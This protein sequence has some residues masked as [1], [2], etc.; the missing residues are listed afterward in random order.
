MAGILTGEGVGP[1][2]ISAALQVLQAIEQASGIA[3]QLRYGGPIGLAALRDSGTCLSPEVIDFC[4]NVFADGGCIFCGP[5]GGDF[6]YRLRERFDLY[7]KFTPIHELAAL[8]GVSRIKPAYLAG[9]DMIVVRENSAGLYLGDSG[10]ENLPCG[11]RLATHQ[12]RYKSSQVERILDVARRLAQ[13]RRGS[14]TVVTKPGGIP[15]ISSLWLDALESMETEG[16]TVRRLEI[17]YAI[18]QLLSAPHE[19]DVIVAPN[20]FGDVLSD[21]AALLMGARGVSY[22]G[23]FG[24]AGRAVYQTGHG[25]AKDLAG[26]NQA[27]PLGQIQSLAMMLRESFGLQEQAQWIH[28]AIDRVLRAGWRTLDIAEPDSRVV[29]TREMGEIVADAVQAEADAGQLMYGS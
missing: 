8:H 19:F 1:E 29:G 4:T 10:I 17:D 20:M 18:Y 3:V 25:A 24:P 5:G 11:D 26:T 12:F 9:I 23:N 16:L 14:L 21:A 7:C 2:V 27:N 15:A 22:S 13:A 6:V 28:R